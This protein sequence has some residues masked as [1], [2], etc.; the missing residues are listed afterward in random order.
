MIHR[1]PYAGSFSQRA[2]SEEPLHLSADSPTRTARLAA[3]LRIDPQSLQRLAQLF[4]LTGFAIAQPLLDVTGRAPEFFVHQRAGRGDIMLFVAIVTILPT[5]ALWLVEQIA[6]L[7]GQAVRRF[8]HICF[9]V[10][11]LTALAIQVAKKLIPDRGYSLLGLGLVVGAAA[12]A[13]ITRSSVAKT[14][15]NYLTPAPLAFA[16]LFV[17]TTP[18]GALL[19]KPAPAA[20]AHAGPIGKRPPIVMIIF[21]EFP[22]ESLL[23]PSG[24][25]DER[26]FPNFARLAQDSTWFR[27]A[28]GV[29]RATVLAVPSMLT[30]RYPDKALAPSYRQYPNSLFTLLSR[31]YALQVSESLT[32]LCPRDVCAAARAVEE[33]EEERSSGLVQVLRESAGVTGQIVS[34]FKSNVDPADQFA[35]PAA[36]DDTGAEQNPQDIRFRV[37]NTRLDQPKRF[38]DFV[39]GLAPSDRPTLHFLHLLLPHTP[40]RYLPSGATYR[41][42]PRI[43][44]DE[45][46]TPGQPP[47]GGQLGFRQRFLLQVAY[48]DKLVGDVI[49]RLEA[50]G[51][52]DDALIVMTADHGRVFDS[53]TQQRRSRRMAPGNEHELAYVPTFIKVPGQRAGRIDDR[54][55]EQVD[56]LPTIADVLD[57][58]V[59]WRVDG[60]SGL[61]PERRHGTDRFW[62]PAPGKPTTWSTNGPREI[63]MRGVTGHLARPEL[64]PAGLYAFGPHR[65][66]VGRKV[67]SFDIGTPSAAR[68][69]VNVGPTVRIDRA[70]AKQ[71]YHVWGTIDGVPTGT[72]IAVAVNGT[73]AAVPLVFR[74][75]K[76][77]PLQLVAMTSDALYRNGTNSITFHVVERTGDEVT[78]RPM[79]FAKK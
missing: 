65:D 70:K 57:V 15:I 75:S 60:F 79:Q 32:E 20:R 37:G 73:V 51:L 45:K 48:T 18:V 55:W 21:D 71:P 35:E 11:L 66:L 26:L 47:T 31:D 24:L 22:T 40:Y 36:E 12:T 46:R 3:H 25:I 9:V 77:V 62:L 7:A 44:H 38:T 28:S 74:H 13:V 39:A 33:E 2:S 1:Q 16:L 8:V 58:E 49:N 76:S 53:G 5:L 19:T 17:A 29:S 6:G 61:G 72:G 64:G 4:V 69:V 43:F 68:A 42:A 27:Q 30:G 23:T 54:N 59:P 63:M 78:L 41:G 10:A 34:P 67:N 52:Y 56:L 14:F 50:Q